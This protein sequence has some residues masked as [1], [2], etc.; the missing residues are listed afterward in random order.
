MLLGL[1]LG[2]GVVASTFG[3][4]GGFLMTPLLVTLFGLPMYVIVAATLPFVTVQ[5]LVGLF[6][7]LVMVPA[8]TG[9]YDPPEW[10]FGLFVAG[11]A[12]F[13]AWLA[14]KTQ[15]FV[16]ESYL[17]L[18]A[19]VITGVGGLLYVINYVVPLPFRI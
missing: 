15:R 17:K 19:G 12:V 3:V 4:G 7:Y 8:L 18:V 6:S 2:V 13:G 9:R 14:A 11:P 5:S 10:A 16:P 1:G